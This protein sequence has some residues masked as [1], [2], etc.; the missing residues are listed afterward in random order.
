M[1]HCYF[2]SR[3][4]RVLSV[5]LRNLVRSLPIY[6]MRRAQTTR[7]VSLS[8]CTA[9]LL[10]SRRSSVCSHRATSTL[11]RLNQ[12]VLPSLP[13]QNAKPP[14]LAR[15]PHRSPTPPTA[16]S[17]MHCEERHMLTAS[18]DRKRALLRVRSIS[19]RP[20]NIIYCTER[21]IVTNASISCSVFVHRRI[22]G[23]VTFSYVL[24]LR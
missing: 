1:K 19:G 4:A 23:C 7:S 13:P 17:H 10:G 20:R 14:S 16:C 22:Y 3:S 2:Q 9:R 6:V 11:T 8:L 21:G 18:P 5:A 24:R 12:P 15:L